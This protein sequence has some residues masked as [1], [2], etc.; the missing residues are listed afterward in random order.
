MNQLDKEKNFLSTIVYVYNNEKDLRKFLPILMNCLES[1]FLNYEIIFVC[2][3][4]NDGSLNYI[5]SLFNNKDGIVVSIVNM[6]GHQGIEA[7][8]NAGVDIS[9]GDFILEF[10][11]IAFEY[12]SELIMQVY[13]KQISENLDIVSVI[14]QTINHLSSRLFYKVFNANNYSHGNLT[15]ELFHIISRRAVNRMQSLN[16]NIGYRK[17]A[18]ASCGLKSAK[19][20]IMPKYY[21]PVV[22]DEQTTYNR[23]NLAIHSLILYTDAIQ[24]LSGIISA[25]FLIISITAG[26]YSLVAYFSPHR[27]ITGWTSMILFLSISFFGV[28]LILTLILIYLSAILNTVYKQSKYIVDSIE[29]I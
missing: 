2:D 11:N 27:P 19:I 9:I 25:V 8:M 28:F 21:H 3:D 6:G 24:K 20:S 5:K 23:N 15:Q 29:K 7:S 16:K 26:I 1:H 13:Q 12:S 10:D 14:P 22:Y 4:S 18:Y 17:A